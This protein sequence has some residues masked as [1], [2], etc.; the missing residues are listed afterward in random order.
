MILGGLAV[1]A[2]N[3]HSR[4]LHEHHKRNQS[5]MMNHYGRMM[6]MLMIITVAAM[7]ALMIT[8]MAAA[9]EVEV[10][11]IESEKRIINKNPSVDCL[12]VHYLQ[13]GGMTLFIYI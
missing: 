1:I 5:Q 7:T 2:K 3:I 6:A 4:I 12:L 10:L 8:T 11:G 13:K 9:L